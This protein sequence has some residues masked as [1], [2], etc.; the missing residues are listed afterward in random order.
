M[1]NSARISRF[2]AILLAALLPVATAGC[3]TASL[4]PADMTP[5]SRTAFAFDTVI[6]ISLYG[7]EETEAGRLL[8]ACME[9]ADH[10]DSEVFSAHNEQSALWK[11]NHPDEPS[12]AKGASD[13]ELEELIRVGLDWR[14]RTQGAF[15]PSLGT[16][17]SLWNFG[18]D[19]P[20]PVPSPEAI[21]EALSMTDPK[22]K[23]AQY[24][25]GGIAKGYI[26]DR[27]KAY[28]IQNGVTSAV[29]N[30][31]GNVLVI[32]EKPDGSAFRVGIRD[33]ESALS[34]DTQAEASG[35]ILRTVEVRGKSVVTSGIYERTF[36]EDGVRY[37]HVLDPATGYPA[38]TGLLSVT[39]LSDDSVTGD[40]LST[41]CLVLGREKGQ[42]LIESLPDTEALFVTTDGAVTTTSGWH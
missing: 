39:I 32:G 2:A 21:A 7:R 41:A 16:L 38:D 42:A 1:S 3:G 26:A 8:D 29:I 25:L 15:S 11:R 28:L 18:G 36:V 6:R 14:S 23:D 20:G 30:L 22:D 9:M 33:P 34:G 10:Y 37:H 5:V 4:K 24:D 19:P 17:T 35:Q 12:A 27:L 13:P 40:A 31:G